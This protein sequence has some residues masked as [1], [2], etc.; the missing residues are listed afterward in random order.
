MY[1]PPLHASLAS[2]RRAPGR[3]AF[4]SCHFCY[5]V[6]RLQNL[7][8]RTTCDGSRAAVRVVVSGSLR[9]RIRCV[10]LVQLPITLRLHTLLMIALTARHTHTH[11][12]A[13]THARTCR[14]DDRMELCVCVRQFSSY[15]LTSHIS[16]R[17]LWLLKCSCTPHLHTEGVFRKAV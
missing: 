7:I 10:R 13:R 3:G 16:L 6:C 4:F 2:P 5:D 1:G 9:Y 12:R 17:S 15:A 11:T 14:S 8:Q